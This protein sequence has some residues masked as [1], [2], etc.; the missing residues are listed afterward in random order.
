MARVEIPTGT[1]AND[2]NGIGIRNAFILINQMMSEIYGGLVPSELRN[3][4]LTLN[5]INFM[6]DAERLK[7]A[8]IEDALFKGVHSS[9]GAL[10]SVHPLPSIGSYA[11]IDAGL[12]ED[13]TVWIWDSN[14]TQWVESGVSGVETP[15]SV[16]SKYEQ[17]EDTNALSDDLLLKLNSIA[18]EA[19]VNVVDSD[20]S[21]I[22]GATQITN[23]VAISQ[24]DYDAIVAPDIATF[25]V[26]TE[27]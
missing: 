6:T 19:E 7:L 4:L 9:I 12:G 1:Q 5:D 14:D 21:G 10:Q 22:S 8:E 3:A 2:G 24:E 16:K 23:I 25:Y 18:A 11:F 13:A 27:A 17:N 15:A 20:T 26:I